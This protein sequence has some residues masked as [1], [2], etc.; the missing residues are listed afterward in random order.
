[1]ERKPTVYVETTIP[2]YLTSD[3]SRDLIIAANQQITHTWWRTAGETYRLVTSQAVVDEAGRGNLVMA[4]KRLEI[5]NTIEILVP[6]E[7]VEELIDVYQRQLGL[8]GVAML[9]IVHIAY[10]AAYN[11]EGLAT[12]NCSHIA[13]MQV[14][15]RLQRL[16]ATLGRPTPEITTPQILAGLP[17]ITGDKP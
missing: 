17:A 14:I 2:S 8:T 12:W 5:L 13:N 11:V 7:D 16:N 10:A 3:P 4:A 9:D 6:N 1:M 15:R